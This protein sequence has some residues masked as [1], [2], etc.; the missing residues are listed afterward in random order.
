MLSPIEDF[1]KRIII[2]D[3]DSEYQEPNDATEIPQDE[4]I[5]SNSAKKKKV[6]D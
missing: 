3:T 1:M 4:E 5:N 2:D 6:N